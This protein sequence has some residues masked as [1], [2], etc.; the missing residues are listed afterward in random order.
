[1]ASRSAAAPS[2]PDVDAEERDASAPHH[3]LLQLPPL[4]V[5]ILSAPVLNV[6]A[7]TVS[8]GSQLLQLRR[9][10]IRFAPAF[11]ADA[12]LGCAS[13]THRHLLQLLLRVEILS[14]PVLSV[15]A[16]IASAG[17]KRLLLLRVEIPSAPALSVDASPESANAQRARIPHAA[18][19]WESVSLPHVMYLRLPPR[20]KFRSSEL[21]TC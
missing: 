13:A 12:S 19:R 14:A 7:R 11:N 17:S 15:D 3:R 20:N 18:S 6:D 10:E 1:V 9:A 2:V 8:A 16:R 21:M 5:V 4:L